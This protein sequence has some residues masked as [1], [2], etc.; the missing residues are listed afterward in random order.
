MHSIIISLVVYCLELVLLLLVL[1]RE[2]RRQLVVF[3]AFIT[4][5]VVRDIA[6]AIVAQT[7]FSNSFEWFYI[8]WISE[9]A[10][11]TMY[12]FIIA[13]IARRSL[14]GYPSVWHPASRLL[15]LVGLA[16][17]SW[18]VISTM[19]YLGHLRLFVMVGDRCLVLTITV[20]L[21]LLLAIDAYYRLKLPPLY[22]LI[23]VGIGIYTSIEVFANEFEIRS[24]NGYSIWFDMRLLSFATALI[25]WI[26]G[27][28]RWP[29]SLAPQAE[30]IPQSK[31]DDLSS[32]VHNRLRNVVQKL[33]HLSGQ[34]S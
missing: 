34:G 13:E 31:Y 9:F 17:M 19:R 3:T 20:L 1:R 7:S 8:Y 24:R 26:Y 16:L 32:Q 25:V 21:L 15:A 12:L 22:R 28:W 2:F 10:L 14:S 6:C 30:L 18:T 33:A 4:L 29:A 5:L 23:L 11:S 27:V